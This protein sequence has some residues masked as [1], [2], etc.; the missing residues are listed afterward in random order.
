MKILQIGKRYFPY[1]GG[2][3]Q[4]S[5]D[6]ATALRNDCEQ[7]MICYNHNK[8]NSYDTVDGLDV[9][10]V[11]CFATIASQPLST[12]YSKI[13]GKQI[14][15][16]APDVIIFHY[17]NPFAAHCLLKKLKKYPKC[18]LII[19]WHADIIK[20]KFIGKFFNRQNN[21]LLQ[22]AWKVVATS[23]IYIEHSPF[24]MKYK[25]K[26][27][28]IPSC[29]DANRLELTE[30]NKIKS[31]EIRNCNA[32]KT[33]CFGLGRHIEYKGFEYL[34][35]AAD[36]LD[37]SFKIYI[38]GEGKL[39]KEL[40]KL[41]KNN[42][43]IEFLGKLSDDDVKSYINACDIFCFPSI[44][45][46]EAFGL[47]LAEAMSFGKPAVTFTISGSGVN[48]V[49]LNGV[50]GIEV[51]NKNAEQYAEAI[52]T[53]AQNSELREE[54][55]AAAKERVQELFTQE[56]FSDNVVQLIFSLGKSGQ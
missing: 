24:L 55:G 56:V 16:F 47:A 14:K 27:I 33:I 37:D 28:V 29:V 36:K 22:R 39:T 26:C 1:I 32:G 15:D 30:E 49:S 42:K 4:T 50:T 3:E 19:W 44:T 46:N 51:E 8:G 54:Y 17:P 20:Q 5:K 18:K 48:Y 38:G 23:P 21:K 9:V 2:I 35:K 53:L 10:R 41:A 12:S 52:K 6:I 13:L 45:K 7:R 40:K 43:N 25:D 34:I 31:R 11:G